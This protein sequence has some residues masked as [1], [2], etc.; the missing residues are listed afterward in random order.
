MFLFYRRS[1]AFIGGQSSFFLIPP[2]PA[3]S[4]GQRGTERNRV[5][6]QPGQ[7]PGRI[8]RSPASGAGGPCRRGNIGGNQ[9]PA[10]HTQPVDLGIEQAQMQPQ[11]VFVGAIT[12]QRGRRGELCKPQPRRGGQSTP[13]PPR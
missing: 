9:A 10:S 4:A 11:F 13:P 6:A 7:K 2:P 3:N 12:P 1:S 5:V 8:N